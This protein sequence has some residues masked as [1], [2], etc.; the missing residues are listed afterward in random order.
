MIAIRSHAVASTER[1]CEIISS[2]M[3]RAS[4]SSRRRVR[5]CSCTMTSRAVVGS[6]AMMMSGSQ[7]RAM[8]IMTRCFCPP[9]SSCGYACAICA[10][11]S[12]CSSRLRTRALRSASERHS[13]F[14]CRLSASR[15]CLPTG[16]TGLSECRAPWN[17][18]AASDQRTARIWPKFSSAMSVPP[19]STRPVSVA[20][21]GSRRSTERMSVDLPEPDS[22]AMPSVPPAGSSRLTFDTAGMSPREVRDEYVIETSSKTRSLPA[23]AA[24]V[25][26][27]LISGS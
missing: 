7:A 8:A 23:A 4:T 13:S 19:N 5:I 14:T 11:R 20:L 18:I 3:P 16:R 22:P 25:S 6:S 1:S 12:T 17:T 27:V 10:S 15:I 21:S 2:E 9:D 24:A 26:A